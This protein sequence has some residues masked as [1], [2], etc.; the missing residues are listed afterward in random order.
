MLSSIRSEQ[1]QRFTRSRLGAL[2][3]ILHPLAQAAIFALI[4]SEVLSAKLP[5]VANKAGYAI[6]LT[7]GMAAWGLFSE[8]TSRCMT[9]FIDYAGM[10]KKIAFP[11]MCLPLIVGGS[12]LFNHLMLLG[13]ICVVFA[14]FDHWPGAAWLV[15]PVAFALIAMFAFGLGVLLGIFNVF[16]RDVG[17]VFGVL[18]Q[19]WFWLTPIVYTPET[20]PESLRWIVKVNPLAPLIRIYQEALVYNALPNWSSVGV[21]AAIAGLLFVGSF[22]LFRRASADLVDAL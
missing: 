14:F 19:I 22:A 15:L 7:A 20:L 13:A 5:G 10:L 2:W 6:Y 9:I 12:A 8:I 18:F 3:F 17:Q 21:P 16:A 11:R 4:L 1:I